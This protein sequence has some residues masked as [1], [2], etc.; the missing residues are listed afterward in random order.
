MD[1]GWIVEQDD[2]PLERTMHCS[3]RRCAQGDGAQNVDLL[4]TIK[5]P[6]KPTHSYAS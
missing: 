5:T 4:N 1:K 6:Q 3:R 2:G